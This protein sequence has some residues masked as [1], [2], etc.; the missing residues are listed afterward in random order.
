MARDRRG[1]LIKNL[2]ERPLTIR[3]D[4]RKLE[5]EAGEEVAVTAEEVR[6]ATLR[7]HLQVR[8][9]AVVRPTTSEENDELMRTLAEG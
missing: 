9:I 4:T 8:T 7:E 6:D 1:M 5:L 2:S 3:M